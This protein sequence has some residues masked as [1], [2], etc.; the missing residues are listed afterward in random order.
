MPTWT[1]PSV[2]SLY[3]DWP[4]LLSARADSQAKMF[5]DGVTWTGL[6]TGTVRW[7]TSNDRFEK[8]NGSSWAN[9]SSSLTA[10]LKIAN[11]LSE[12][13]ASPAA[14]RANLGLGAAALLGTPIP[15]A[16]GG[17]GGTDQATARA[18]L[19][20]LSMSIQAAS[21]V[22]ITGGTLTGITALT[23]TTGS[24]L[25]LTSGGT[26]SNVGTITAGEAVLIRTTGADH[27]I[28]LS[29]NSLARFAVHGAGLIPGANNTYDLGSASFIMKD[30]YADRLL[31]AKISNASDILM[32]ISGS[33][34]WVFGSGGSKEFR[35]NA[36]NTQNLGTSSYYWANGYMNAI[37]CESMSGKNGSTAYIGL[38][39]PTAGSGNI[40]LYA[41]NNI[42]V[43]AGS[44]FRWYFTSTGKLVPWNASP[45]YSI[46]YAWTTD[47]SLSTNTNLAELGNVVA[48]I[49]ADLVTLG[50]FV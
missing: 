11:N 36:T 43:Y 46:D 31:A 13:A 33:T 2:A 14:A 23:M 42:D 30:I 49:I 7:N 22:A 21:A 37:S 35:P 48:T 15:V 29:T 19:G 39:S 16:S 24:T 27:P 8:W 18:G 45:D 32:Q 28:T 47:R 3:A 44:A 40:V 9:L 26:L 20:L 25:S 12:F 1:L 10:T 38:S 41:S 17:T 50:L 4:N 34:H 6:L 5:D